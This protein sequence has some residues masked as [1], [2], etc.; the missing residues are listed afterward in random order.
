MIRQESAG[1]TAYDKTMLERAAN[2]ES[3]V[4]CSVPVGLIE[5][6]NPAGELVRILREG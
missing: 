3:D 6:S 2:E 5:I 4:I 1:E